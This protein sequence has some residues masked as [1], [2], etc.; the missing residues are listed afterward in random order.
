MWLITLIYSRI[1]WILLFFLKKSYLV[2]PSKNGLSVLAINI[3]K[4]SKNKL[5]STTWFVKVIWRVLSCFVTP[6]MAI[7]VK[8]A[9]LSERVVIKGWKMLVLRANFES[10]MYNACMVT[11]VR[12]RRQRKQPTIRDSLEDLPQ[13]QFIAAIAMY[14]FLYRFAIA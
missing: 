10:L 7:A 8:A 14:Q 4:H 1:T 2:T 3:N 9:D 6:R 5:Y 11:L 13:L 12:W